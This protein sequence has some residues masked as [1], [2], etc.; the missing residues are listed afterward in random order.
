VLKEIGTD[1]SLKALQSA[2]RDDKN[3]LVKKSAAEAVEAIKGRA[4]EKA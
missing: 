3:G 4:A 2:A 1:K